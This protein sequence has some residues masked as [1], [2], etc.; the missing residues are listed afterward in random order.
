MFI[1]AFSGTPC[2]L[3]DL[4]DEIA[5]AQNYRHKKVHFGLDLK[6]KLHADI[7]TVPKRCEH[8]LAANFNVLYTTGLLTPF[9]IGSYHEM[10]TCS[11]NYDKSLK[12]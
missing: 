4:K 8:F 12:M 1:P 9:L 6:V 5:S 7:Q 10:F 11:A 3:Q 2:I